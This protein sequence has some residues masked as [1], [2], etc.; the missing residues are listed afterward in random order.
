PRDLDEH[1]EHRGIQIGHYS[2]SDAPLP[3]AWVW[4]PKSVLSVRPQPGS[5]QVRRLS[6]ARRREGGM[7]NA[8][9]R[10]VRLLRCRR[11]RISISEALDALA[12]AGAPEM[13]VR[14]REQLRRR[15][16]GV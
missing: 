3:T 11:M 8:L 1:V 13:M 12:C 16:E 10:F 15:G 5:D 14:A 9:H 7:E 2:I 4:G 6:A